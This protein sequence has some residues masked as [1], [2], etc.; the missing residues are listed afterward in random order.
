MTLSTVMTDGTYAVLTAY[1][2]L[3]LALAIRNHRLKRE[4]ERW[5]QHV[6]SAQAAAG[7]DPEPE[8]H[9]LILPFTANPQQ[10]GRQQ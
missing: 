1:A 2:V 8:H 3:V 4:S 9:A 6:A 7:G 5:E 10:G